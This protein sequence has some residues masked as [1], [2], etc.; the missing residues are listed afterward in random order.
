MNSVC[1]N[2]CTYSEEA[3]QNEAFLCVRFST[4]FRWNGN[5][6]HVE[7][8]DHSP[9]SLNDTER[10]FILTCGVQESV[11]GGKGRGGP[12]RFGSKS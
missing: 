12:D 7:E 3:F 11:K 10:C 4:R 6:E 9:L 1:T 2:T 5:L 8:V